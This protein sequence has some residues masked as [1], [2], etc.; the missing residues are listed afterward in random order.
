MITAGGRNVLLY[1]CLEN[2][3]QIWSDLCG[4]EINECKNDKYNISEIF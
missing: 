3:S 4:N 1:N 2:D